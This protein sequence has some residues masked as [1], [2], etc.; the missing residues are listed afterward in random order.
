LLDGRWYFSERRYAGVDL[1]G[2][3]S[4]HLLQPVKG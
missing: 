3:M 1:S 4:A 2:D